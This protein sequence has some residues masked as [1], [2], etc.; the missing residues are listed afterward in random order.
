M[1]TATSTATVNASPVPA[2]KIAQTAAPRVASRTR[3]VRSATNE[4]GMLTS[5]PAMTPAATMP[6]AVESDR[7]KWSRMSGSRTA[8]PVRSSSSTALRPNSTN[9][10]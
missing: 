7:P 10:G 5:R 4:T 8:K 6:S 1:R 2:E 3:L 9:R